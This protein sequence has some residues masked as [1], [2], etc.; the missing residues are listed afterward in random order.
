MRSDGDLL[1]DYARSRSEEAFAELVSRHLDFVYS[2]ALRMVG[3]DVHLAQDIAQ[4]VFIDF[5][6]KAGLLGNQRSIEGWLYQAT[7]YAAAKMVRSEQRRAAREREAVLMEANCDHETNWAAIAPKVDE[8]LGDLG[9]RDR[10][11]VLLRFFA[12][13]NLRAVAEATGIT[14]EA[15]RKRVTR[16]LEKMRHYLTRRGLRISESAL[17]AALATAAGTTAPAGFA[18]T[19]CSA[20]FSA[21]VV[22]GV[23]TVLMFMATAKMKMAGAAL[24]L[25]VVTVPLVLQQRTISELQRANEVLGGQL[26]QTQTATP[27]PPTEAKTMSSAEQLELMRLRAEVTALRREVRERES[28]RAAAAPASPNPPDDGK[29]EFVRWAETILDGPAL[30][31]GAESGIVRRKALRGEPL[32]DGEKTLLFNMVRRAGE[33]EKVPEEF[34]E[35][36]SAFVASLLEWGN[37]ARTK[38][39]KEI[40]RAAA[41]KANEAHMDFHAPGQNADS[42]SAEQKELNRSATAAVQALL[43]ESE[44]AVFDPALLG[45]MGIDFGVGI[46]GH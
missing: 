23:G 28:N 44:R 21:P 45:V 33:I 13:K 31:K 42:W 12:K 41:L 4:G 1:R 30:M 8:A 35:F 43:S 46:S 37:D 34:A 6:R 26:V 40:I 9:E 24:I 18:A 22:G 14:E 10:E 2:T 32:N 27:P 11:A 29:P 17:V 36:Q 15:A 16:A 20:V 38:Q 25:G 7:R 19:V 3:G 5:A 39:V